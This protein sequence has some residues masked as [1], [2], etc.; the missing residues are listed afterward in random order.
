M[1]PLSLY[2]G[3]FFGLALVL[4]C[5]AFVVRPKGALAAIAA[6]VDSPDLI[7][8]TGIMTMTAGAAA[9]IG[10]NLWSG[11]AVT[12]AVT[13]LAWVTLIKGFALIALPPGALATLYGVLG[14]PQRF[15]LVMALGLAFG[16]W[17]SWAAFSAPGP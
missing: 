15:R 3:R 6:M 10:H 17:L 14:Y 9:V 16:L 11:G 1:S 2:L 8:V 7:L 13:V 4:M 12:I 5:L